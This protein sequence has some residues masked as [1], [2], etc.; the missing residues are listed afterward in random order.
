MKKIAVLLTVHNRK[1]KTLECLRNLYSQQITKDYVFD[2]YL[3]DDGCTDGTSEAVSQEFPKINIV[4][5][6]GNLFWNRGMHAAW[7]EAE[8]QCY[9]FYLWLNDD[10]YLLDNALSYILNMSENRCNNSIIIGTTLDSEMKSLTYGG[11]D[12]AGR[13]I[14]EVKEVME[15]Y[16]W[17][18]NIVLI[19][20]S[21][22]ERVGKNDPVFHHAIGDTDY[23][24][25][26]RKFQIKSYLSDKPCGICDLHSSIP[27]W[28]DPQQTVIKRLKYLYAPGNNGSNPI[29]FFI[30]KKR[31]Y[32]LFKAV[33]T[34]LSNHLHALFPRLWNLM[35]R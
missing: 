35:G 33:L 7:S 10:T 9:D 23:G 26:A 27:K 12:K 34:F 13:F 29:D 19:P 6:D 1:Q 17:N 2:V 4:K 14:S 5:G 24:L 31:H 8:K 28:R 21:V 15:C 20:K 30:F 18:G 32:G 16:T 25:R 22:Y 3:T 11:F